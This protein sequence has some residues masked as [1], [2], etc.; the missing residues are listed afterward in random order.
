M[1]LAL[2]LVGVPL[3]SV[4]EALRQVGPLDLALVGL[5][6]VA[7]HLLRAARQAVLV[8]GLAPS[9][10]LRAHLAILLISF[11]AIQVV[12]AR[13]GELVRPVL[14]RERLGLSLGEGLA[15]ILVERLLDLS[16]AL[17]LVVFAGAVV[18]VPADVPRWPG[19]ELDA[20]GLARRG[21]TGLLLTVGSATAAMALL[22]PPLLARLAARFEA[23]TSPGAALLRRVLATV[24]RGARGLRGVG[25]ARW[26][27]AAAL[28]AGVW[29]CGVGM[30]LLAARASGLGPLCGPGEA[31]GTLG[32]T[33]LGGV[34]PAPPAQAGT[35][36]ALVRA[37]MATMGIQGDAP[38]LGR[39]GTV[40]GAVLATAVLI[41]WWPL[42]IQAALGGIALAVHRV[43]LPTLVHGAERARQEAATPAL[44][45]RPT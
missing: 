38:L 20:L 23:G 12:P 17:A 19:T 27:G 13:L 31:S 5:V 9:G 44:E 15:V 40:E 6:F 39:P 34:L 37:G 30:L 8:G 2:A 41:H 35:F 26:L 3:R 32:I 22:G 1:A 25:A 7:G 33:L 18:V 11:L 29:T 21:A 28:T 16:A 24:E 36:E 43:D 42:L 4:G 45:G 10:G 14:L